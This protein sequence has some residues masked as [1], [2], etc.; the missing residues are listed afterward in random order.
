MPTQYKRGS[1]SRILTID[2]QNPL[3]ASRDG[4][5]YPVSAHPGLVA[6]VYRQDA[7]ELI[8]KLLAMIDS[9]PA[10]LPASH[11]HASIEWPVDL[12]YT[13]DLRD[14]V[15]VLLPRL[16]P[17]VA[18]SAVFN[19][20]T[21]RRERPAFTYRHLYRTASNLTG[22]VSTL[23]QQQCVVGE[24]DAQMALVTDA[25]LVT[26][27]ETDA[28]QIFDPKTRKV[29][30]CL[31]GR[32]E[33]T[34]PELQNVSFAEVDR[35]PSS[36]NFSLAVLVFQLLM[37]GLY[38]FVAESSTGQTTGGYKE[39]ALNGRSV[40]DRGSGVVSVV[41][42]ALPLDVLPETL[43]QLFK[44]CFNAGRLDPSARP[45]AKEWF[46]ALQEAEARLRGQ[47][48]ASVSSAHEWLPMVPH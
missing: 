43:Q 11:G 1:D 20:T 35:E 48:A 26:L 42:G 9:P 23:H 14:C 37:E 7:N 34:A 24:L 21:R 40:L 47:R 18:L 45:N 29:F 19:Q 38:P 8:R 16:S 15:G 17:S 6:K 13:A 4:L 31:Y 30:R 2:A 44:R 22:A 28:Y 10:D 46:A 33:Y 5:F 39:L 41:P 36:D 27:T 3:R 32:P 25:A 12:L